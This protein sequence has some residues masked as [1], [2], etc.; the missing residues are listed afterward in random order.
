MPGMTLRQYLA[1]QALAGLCANPG[2][3][4]EANDMSG[5][6]IVNCTPADVA[7]ECL[8]LADAL[9]DKTVPEPSALGPADFF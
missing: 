3:P 4:F 8:R 9:I 2:G 7:A 5:W 1:G 6:G